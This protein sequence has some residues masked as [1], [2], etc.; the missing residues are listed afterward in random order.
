MDRI[1]VG[2]VE[3]VAV[4]D[5]LP[6]PYEQTEFFP[7]VLA[8]AWEGDIATH[9][10]GGKLQLYYGCFA[11]RAGG[12]V[13]LVDTGKGPGPHADRGQPARRPAQ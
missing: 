10:E 2:N 1:R 6:P 7:G 3:V 4:L 5:M 11:L 9:L 12:R 8:E 13:I